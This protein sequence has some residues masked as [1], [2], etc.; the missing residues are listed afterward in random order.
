MRERNETDILLV[1]RLS[2]W[3]ERLIRIGLAKR[4]LWAKLADAGQ[5]GASESCSF[6]FDP[7]GVIRI[8][9]EMMKLNRDAEAVRMEMAAVGA[10]VIDPLTFEVLIVGGP[11]KGSYLSWMPG[12]TRVGWW[13][14]Q[15]DI[16]SDRR[17]LPGLDRKDVGANSH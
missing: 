14:K 13:R 2:L 4:V 3:T 15:K 11:K 8:K 9:E 5:I 12:E 16:H 6:S 10:S 1:K 7:P 17:L